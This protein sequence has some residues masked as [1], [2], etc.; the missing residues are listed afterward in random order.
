MKV[1][2]A[3]DGSDG[4]VRAT[5]Y[6]LGHADVFGVSPEISLVNVHLP[7]PSPR[8]RAWLG[9]DALNS[10]YAEESEQALAT[11]RGKIAAKGLKA[12]EIMRVGD[13]GTEI[14]KAAG[15]SGCSMIV[16]GTHGRSALG[17][18]VMGSVA[19]KVLAQSKVPILL[20][21]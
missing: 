20:V 17:T 12:A 10:Y 6:V 2:I 15:E 11:V 9:Q 18:L 5:D 13:P 8:A 4:C 1:L 21:K 3:I 14:A 19:T 16:M 7:V